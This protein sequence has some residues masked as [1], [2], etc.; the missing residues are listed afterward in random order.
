[1][2][3]QPARVRLIRLRLANFRNYV[4]LDLPLQP[5]SVVFTGDNGAGKTNLLEADLDA[6]ARPRV[7]S[8]DL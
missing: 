3:E 4:A 2:T 5:R 7:A 8:G 1:M 6:D